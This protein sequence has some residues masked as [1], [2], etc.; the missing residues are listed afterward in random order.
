MNTRPDERLPFRELARQGARLARTLPTDALP[1]LAHLAPG[2]GN[3]QANLA[4]SLDA[5]GRPWV[6]GQVGGT[7]RA[8]CQRCLEQFD[9]ALQTRFE[10]CIL[11]DDALATEL[12]EGVDVLA[13]DADSVSVAEV[14]ED[15]LILGLPEQLCVQ[16]PCPYAPALSYPAAEAPVEVDDN[17][18]QVLGVLKK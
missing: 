2:L 13:V 17:P 12:A 5:A 4:F 7:V 18:F 10:L 3:L 8:T 1:R 11:A 9:H 14:V 16:E 6:R 15:E